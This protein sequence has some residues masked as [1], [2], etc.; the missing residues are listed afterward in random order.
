ML[1]EGCACAL[2]VV[3]IGLAG[4]SMPALGASAPMVD[5]FVFAAM[6]VAVL[7]A[8]VLGEVLFAFVLVAV[9]LVAIP[10][11]KRHD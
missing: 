2:V 5:G 4:A 9:T 10:I 11:S 3:D 6:L 8:F 1:A 7:S